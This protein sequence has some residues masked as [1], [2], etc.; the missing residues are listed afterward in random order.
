MADAASR[1]D[2]REDR[3]SWTTSKQVVVDGLTDLMVSMTAWALEV[4]RA[5]MTHDEHGRIVRGEGVAG[6]CA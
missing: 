4:D 1:T 3:S 5:V 2:A 6:R